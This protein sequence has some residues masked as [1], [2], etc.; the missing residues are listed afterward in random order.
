MGIQLNWEVSVQVDKSALIKKAT[1]NALKKAIRQTAENIK[2][3][4][5]SSIENGPKTGRIYRR[6]SQVSFT[7]RSGKQVSFIAY[8]GSKTEHQASAPG[9]APATD[10]G[11]LVG[12]I[13]VFTGNIDNLEAEVRTNA[14]YAMNLEVGTAHIEPRPFMVPAVRRNEQPFRETVKAIVKSGIENA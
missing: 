13:E 10:T 12:S 14:E 2:K 3:D 4:M 11:N 5:A 7:T 1:R 6:E 9:E 8:K